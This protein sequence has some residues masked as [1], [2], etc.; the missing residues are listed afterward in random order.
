MRGRRS[1]LLLA[2]VLAACAGADAKPRD[3]TDELLRCYERRGG[4][5]VTS[6]AQL[7]SVSSRNPDFGSGFWLESVHVDSIYVEADDDGDLVQALALVSRPSVQATDTRAMG[8]P[9]VLRRARNGAFEGI[10]VVLLP[11]SKDSDRLV[12]RCVEEVA[13]DELLP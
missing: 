8:A 5:R 7:A 3:K 1:P 10:T 6:P 9:G 12:T 13:M 11:V 4:E 2:L